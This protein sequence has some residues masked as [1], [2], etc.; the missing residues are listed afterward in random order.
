ME[1]TEIIK[2]RGSTKGRIGSRGIT[3]NDKHTRASAITLSPSSSQP[4]QANTETMES[5]DVGSRRR[6]KTL[7]ETIAKS[8]K[9][10]PA[11]GWTVTQ[12][13]LYSVQLF[14]IATYPAT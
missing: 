10:Q 6:I 3:Q 13:V 11:K 14:L 4:T 8:L 7:K 1:G 9:P 12:E 5:L 2:R